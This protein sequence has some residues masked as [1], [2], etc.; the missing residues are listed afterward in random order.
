MNLDFD[1]YFKRN[2][3]II[4]SWFSCQN[5]AA[6]CITSITTNWRKRGKKNAKKA[7]LKLCNTWWQIETW[8]IVCSW[9]EGKC[10]L[11]FLPPAASPACFLPCFQAYWSLVSF[12]VTSQEQGDNGNRQ[13]FKFLSHPLARSEWTTRKL[14]WLKP[15]FSKSFLN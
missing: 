15:V 9:K 3:S 11:H 1:N 6:W 2:S 14:L 12:Q 10:P 8:I 7:A 4:L 5:V 13:T